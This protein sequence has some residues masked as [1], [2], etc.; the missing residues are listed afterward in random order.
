MTEASHIHPPK[1]EYFDTT[2]MTNTDPKGF[3]RAV[4]R[5]ATYPWGLYL[6][7]PSD[8]QKFHY[9]ESWIIPTLGIRITTFHPNPGYL[10]N[11]DHYIDIGEYTE[12]E[13]G[14]WR[15][16]DHYLDV[17]VWTG[18][19]TELLDADE[20]LAAH[21]AG[22]LDTDRATGAMLRAADVIDG[23]AAH[24]YDVAAWLAGREMPI[25]WR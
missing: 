3:V 7:R 14:I 21:S 4:D 19:S 6:A 23:V 17:I 9:I 2:A 16:I 25:S 22:L 24:N 12:I 5:Y 13:P 10:P 15:S 18:R 20:L 1:V 8:H 11:Q